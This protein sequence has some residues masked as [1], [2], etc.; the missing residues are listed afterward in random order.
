MVL[1][2]LCYKSRHSPTLSVCL[3]GHN[4]WTEVFYVYFAKHNLV[5]FASVGI[6][7]TS[8]ICPICSPLQA[9]LQREKNMTER[10][11]PGFFLIKLQLHG[12]L[13]NLVFDNPGCN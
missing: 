4:L 8:T 13:A 12:N 7:V 1:Y 3:I 2:H 6:L 10:S 11:S 9:Y 5:G